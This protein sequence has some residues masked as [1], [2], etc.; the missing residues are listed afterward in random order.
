MKPQ[1][2]SIIEVTYNERSSYRGGRGRDSTYLA[3][4]TR[5]K[6]KN[7]F[8]K[9][10]SYYVFSLLPDGFKLR[11]PSLTDRKMIRANRTGHL[12]VTGVEPGLYDITEQTEDFIIAKKQAN[13]QGNRPASRVFSK[14]K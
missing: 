6:T 4:D 11:L 9:A 7:G 5:A 8:V 14:R 12:C 1:D 2:P 10:A 3:R 13:V